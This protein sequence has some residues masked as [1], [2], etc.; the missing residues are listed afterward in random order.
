MGLTVW[1]VETAHCI[2][3]MLSAVGSSID[4]FLL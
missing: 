1:I 2:E 3:I 4:T